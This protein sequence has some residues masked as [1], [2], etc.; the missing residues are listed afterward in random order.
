M[1]KGSL[2]RYD[3]Q[4]KISLYVSCVAG[5]C[6]VALLALLL[7]NYKTESAAI[8]FKAN[9]MFAPLVYMITVVTMLLSGAG[10]AMGAA[11][12]GQQRNTFNKRSWTAFFVGGLSFSATIILFYLFWTCKFP[13]SV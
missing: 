13:I 11:S 10:A 6:A 12:A 9:G 2:R 4:A 1:A 5:L 3:V 7:R 8:T